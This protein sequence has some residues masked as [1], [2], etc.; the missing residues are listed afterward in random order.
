M[1]GRFVRKP[2]GDAGRGGIANAVVVSLIIL[3][4][5]ASIF[6]ADGLGEGEADG[7]RLE[8]VV[9]DADGV[10]HELRLDVDATLKVETARGVN[11]VA[12]EAG[13]VRVVEASCENQD[14]VRQGALSAPGHQIICLP[15]QLW[16]EVV[17]TG[18]SSGSEAMDVSAVAGAD[19]AG[20]AG[21]GGKAEGSGKAAGSDE[22]GQTDQGEAAAVDT[23]SR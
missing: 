14:C 10:V 16:I 1:E 20:Q 9:H 8:A 5:A 17:E 21:G 13:E 7:S 18:D 12:V 23:L 15:H 4:G 19:A 2:S 11:V 3:A 22:A 6:L